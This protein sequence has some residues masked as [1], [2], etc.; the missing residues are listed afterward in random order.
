MLKIIQR[1]SLS[2]LVLLSFVL[3]LT[4]YCGIHSWKAEVE[5]NIIVTSDAAG[6]ETLAENILHYHTFAGAYDTASLKPD[7]YLTQPANLIYN[8]DSYREPGYPAFL[9]VVYFIAGIKPFVAI[10][11]QILLNIFSVALIYRIALLLFNNRN[12]AVV[13]GLLFAIDI[14]SI[15]VAN[16]LYS[17]TLC[18]FLFLLSLY[19]FLSGI[20]KKSF[21]SF[22]VSAVFMGLACL[23]RPVAL[24]YPFVLIFL[25]LVF[26]RDSGKRL[27]K[28][29]VF[30][31]IITY[32]L[33]GIWVVRNHSTYGKWQLSTMSGYN[34]MMYNVAFAESRK[35]GLPIETVRTKFCNECDSLGCLKMEN[36]F[37][38]ANVCGKVAWNYVKK[39]KTAY[40]ETQVW[41]AIHMF[42]SLG[43]IDMAH[44][45]GWT[46]SD[47]EGQLIMDSRRL[48]QNFSHGGQAILALL[49]I[50]V[51]I[52]QYVGAVAGLFFLIKNKKYFI[53][54][55]AVLT[56]LY[57][58]AVTGAIGK[59]RY[60]LPMQFAI[61]SI[62]GFGYCSLLKRKKE[63]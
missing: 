62:A 48:Q 16:I 61:C 12:I 20:E 41:G 32:G 13:S 21:R 57:F 1:I 51:L 19:Y 10:F 59:Y 52:I 24:L 33:A 38:R 18:I 8:F 56:I 28:A 55:F 60:K 4:M 42:L 23:T 45:L 9:A 35:S 49:I 37:D 30:F 29:M 27:I 40:V 15:F 53:F 39:N 31:M 63:A 58:S 54:Y 7:A 47:V 17:D 25:L 22:L 46:S 26:K 36:P 5:K 43:N 6:Y 34:Q 44:T 3:N 50:L 14:H 2:H 11:L